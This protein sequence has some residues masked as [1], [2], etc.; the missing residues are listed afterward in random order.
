MYVCI[1]V[2]MYICIHVYVYIY[3]YIYVYM[4]MY[5]C[6][7]IYIYISCIY[8]YIHIYIYI[9][10]L[11]YGT[12]ALGTLEDPWGGE[13]GPGRRATN[14][15]PD[16][17]RSL[18]DARRFLVASGRPRRSG[19]LREPTFGGCS[20]YF[21]CFC[22]DFGSPGR[23]LWCNFDN[24]TKACMFDTFLVVFRVILTML[25]FL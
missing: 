14:P 24:K 25:A 17:C 12:R 1:F 13:P 3:V 23:T 18:R 6:I 22:A 15:M 9:S 10:A 5:I 2:Y 20:S 8:I 7:C 4:Y 16:A 21:G 19:A 11:I